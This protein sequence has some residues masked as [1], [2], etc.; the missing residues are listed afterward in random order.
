MKFSLYSSIFTSVFLR[1]IFTIILGNMLHL[2]V[3][4][5]TIAM[6]SDWIVKAILDVIRVGSGRWREK[7]VI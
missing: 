4:G 6:I 5:V 3:I 1:I 2:G 7:R